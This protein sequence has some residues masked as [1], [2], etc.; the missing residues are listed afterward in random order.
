MHTL[1]KLPLFAK[2]QRA[3]SVIVHG[4]QL[5]LK[6]CRKCG[7]DFYAVEKQARCDEC[8]AKRKK[9]EP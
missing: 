1:G 4:K 8:F 7:C 6:E 3:Q 5:F 9:H 2:A